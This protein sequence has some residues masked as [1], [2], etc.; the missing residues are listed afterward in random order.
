MESVKVSKRPCTEESS[1]VMPVLAMCLS[2]VV[3]CQPVVG[4]YTD[5]IRAVDS[6]LV[7]V[8]GILMRYVHSQ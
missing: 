7:V 3:E 5:G 1:Q 2:I 8:F 4:L 6:R